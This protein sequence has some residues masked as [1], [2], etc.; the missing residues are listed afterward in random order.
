MER[1]VESIVQSDACDRLTPAQLQALIGLV[2]ATPA[3]ALPRTHVLF[4]KLSENFSH[5]SASEESLLCVQL[6]L[7]LCAETAQRDV[8]FSM[9]ETHSEVIESV[10]A[11]S[12]VSLSSAEGPD[13]YLSPGGDD[14]RILSLLL[15]VILAAG[16]ET[17]KAKYLVEF[18]GTSVGNAVHALVMLYVDVCGV[19]PGVASVASGPLQT[20]LSLRVV[21]MLHELTFWTTYEDLHAEFG[22]GTNRQKAV[23]NDTGSTPLH[24]SAGPF[25]HY[26]G[27]IISFLIRYDFCRFAITHMSKLTR[28][29]GEPVMDSGAQLREHFLLFKT[30][31]TQ[32]DQ[33][34]SLLRKELFKY[35]V[36][37]HVCA[38]F[39]L[40]LSG[41]QPVTPSN[42]ALLLQCVDVTATMSCRNG[43]SHN[44]WCDNTAALAKVVDNVAVRAS[45]LVAAGGEK[46]FTELVSQLV[47][48][49]V[50]SHSG[51]PVTAVLQ[52]W[53]THLDLVG[54]QRVAHR[55][56]NPQ[57]RRRPIDL[58]S[59]VYDALRSV[60]RI[61]G[62]D[63]AVVG[64]AQRHTRGDS[65][66][67][68]APP[69]CGGRG[70]NRSRSHGREGCRGD[71]GRRGRSR[72]C[73]RCRPGRYR[74]LRRQRMR[75]RYQIL[76]QRS[77]QGEELDAATLKLL[78]AVDAD[79]DSSSSCNSEEEELL[80]VLV[81]PPD[82]SRWRRGP[83]P[84]SIPARYICSL[85]HAFI[86]SVPVLSP[87]GFVFDEDIILDYLK[88]YH[89][90][91]ISG[92]PLSPGELVVDMQLR[93]ELNKVR[94]NFV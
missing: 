34:T 88:Y 7:L 46:T 79:G 68:Q 69:H 94:D 62:N 35:G 31:S 28:S 15:L 77:S 12:I 53:K 26:V 4:Q 50:N 91:P 59:P 1:L 5:L 45:E 70:R 43:Q 63:S 38:P 2:S 73:G 18:V 92:A 24:V 32:T 37:E 47:R 3:I 11:P 57:N 21:Q 60:F 29:L 48:L 78:E 27:Q 17:M 44:F 13:D 16:E 8:V 20:Y 82:L 93:E 86:R 87:T 25:R 36:F 56:S 76:T 81:A 58:C 30:L 42:T 64:A 19:V 84:R 10:V 54:K 66:S 52:L 75:R 55:L 80:G 6:S 41:Q 71:G 74:P 51:R 23:S 72:S 39:M 40:E 49:V 89:V 9:V 61:N 83:P 33:F 65:P 67:Q 22:T 14:R 85:S 90:C